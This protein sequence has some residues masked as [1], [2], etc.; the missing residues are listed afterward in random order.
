MDKP[1]NGMGEACQGKGYKGDRREV[2]K[3]QQK[4]AGSKGKKNVPCQRDDNE[5]VR[6]TFRVDRPEDGSNEGSRRG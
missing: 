3:V 6:K 1:K 5:V 2:K 4:L